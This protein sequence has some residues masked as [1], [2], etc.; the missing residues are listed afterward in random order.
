[1]LV[2]RT[3]GEKSSVVEQI[4]SRLNIPYE[5]MGLSDENFKMC[6]GS[7]VVL[8]VILPSEGEISGKLIAEAMILSQTKVKTTVIFF[9]KDEL[10]NEQADII[11]PII[12]VMKERGVKVFESIED[13]EQYLSGNAKFISNMAKSSMSVQ[14]HAALV[15]RIKEIYIQKFPTEPP[16]KILA[17]ELGHSVETIKKHLRRNTSS[18]D[19]LLN[20]KLEFAK[21]FHNASEE[22]KNILR[23]LALYSAYSS[24]EG[25]L[26]KC[27]KNNIVELNMEIFLWVNNS[28][29]EN[30]QLI[31]Q[32]LK[33]AGEAFLSKK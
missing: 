27:R 33:W 5:I 29:K 18:N 25:F 6:R 15:N 21:Y 4:T 22:K 9:K 28:Q 13:T 8:Y 11:T 26:D 30:Y 3:S 23:N 10:T 17:Q 16:M 31:Y 1:M 12:G 7:K 32:V 24:Y 19:W 2:L 14:E 20:T